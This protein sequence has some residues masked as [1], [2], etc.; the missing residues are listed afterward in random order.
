MGYAA[1][2]LESNETHKP[3]QLS[4]SELQK[5]IDLPDGLPLQ[6]LLDLEQDSGLLD[7]MGAMA[8]ERLSQ[9]DIFDVLGLD[10]SEE[11]H[12]NFMAWL[13]SPTGSHGLGYYFL[14]EF[15]RHVGALNAIRTSGL[16]GV[17]VRRER[18]VALKGDVGR[19]DI[20]ILNEQAKFLCAIENKVW[21]PE[22]GNQLAF[23]R[24]AF[25]ARYPDYKRPLVFVTPRG[26]EPESPEEREHW[27]SMSYT[28]ILR[29]V[30]RATR[31]H[32]NCV[33][34]DV[35]AL[36]RQYAITLRRNIVP[37]VSNDAHK[38]AR[39]IYLKHKRAIDLIAEHR[40]RYEPNYVNEGFWMV[41]D[42]VRKCQEWEEA[43][44]NYPYARFVST[45]WSKYGGF[46]I[47][48]WP[49]TLFQ[50]HV[51]CTYSG[52]Q[53]ALCLNRRGD[54]QLKGKI[55]D[56]LA[57]NPHLFKG[58]LPIY[59][60]NDYINLD[61]DD[62]LTESDYENWWDEEGVRAVIS[63]NLAQFAGG[64]FREINRIIVGCLEEDASGT[65]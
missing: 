8:N 37:E 9:V 31:K 22:T 20:L 57:T 46:K 50:L 41:R 32:G 58:E 13:L 48:D 59:T 6:A 30:E 23:Y 16:A 52:A 49:G 43:T 10:D 35:A 21:A 33:D 42:A 19:L 55:F 15:L 26:V 54:E 11:F 63:H 56:R 60:E 4:E 25:K 3:E 39:M 7:R 5:L 17:T 12:S 53:L 1:Q 65:A 36:L 38:L 34:A 44:C 61:I 29:V 24:K 45:A 27:R 14:R 2:T 28:D 62:I 51:H 64:K 47:D 18:E 40:D